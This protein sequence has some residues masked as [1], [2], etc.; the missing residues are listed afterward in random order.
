MDLCRVKIAGMGYEKERLWVFKIQEESIWEEGDMREEDV[1]QQEE[2]VMSG[3][4][5]KDEIFSLWRKMESDC[6]ILTGVA[7]SLHQQGASRKES[8]VPVDHLLLMCSHLPPH[9]A[10][11]GS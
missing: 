8:W 10:L 1:I 3:T 9:K 4:S 11:S 2:R 7:R 5:L 6:D